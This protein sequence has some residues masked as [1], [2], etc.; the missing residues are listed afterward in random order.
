MR[1]IDVSHLDDDLFFR[2]FF[3]S[4]YQVANDN[5][6]KIHFHSMIQFKTMSFCESR[7]EL[8]LDNWTGSIHQMSHH[9]IFLKN[10]N[11]RNDLMSFLSFHF[12]S[13]QTTTLE[14][15]FLFFAGKV[16]ITFPTPA[17]ARFFC[18]LP[19]YIFKNN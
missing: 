5:K 1:Y 18:F 13:T 7:F 11:F 2:F 15:I 16:K 10:R 3:F 14:T 9:F 19:I 12:L 17:P 6:V 8:Y 4:F